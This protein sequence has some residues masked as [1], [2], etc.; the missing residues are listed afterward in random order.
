[1]PGRSRRRLGLYRV[2]NGRGDN[3]RADSLLHIAIADAR[4]IRD[5]PAE[6]AALFGFTTTRVGAIS[7]LYATMDSIARLL[8]PGDSRDR[9]EYF[10][11]LGVYRGI[12][13]E[14]NALDLLRRGMAMAQRTSERRLVAHC[15]EGY[16]LIHSIRGQ[17]DSALA[18]YDRAAVLLRATHEHAGLSR[19]ESRRSDILQAY[20]RLGEAKVALDRVLSEAAI[21]KNRQRTANAIAGMGMLAL[22]VGDLPTA[23]DTVRAG[24][25]A[26]RFAGPVRRAE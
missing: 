15:L 26:Q 2:A 9:A 10:C 7:S 5:R 20:G 4:R 25:G 11:R 8:P 22:R 18:I 13:G 6:I 16:G 24:G 23:A 21:S 1:M 3:L 19:N 12:G 17:N 14:P